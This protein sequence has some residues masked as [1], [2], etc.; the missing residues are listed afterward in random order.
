MGESIL[1]T[2]TAPSSSR[3]GPI[4]WRNALGLVEPNEYAGA[5]KLERMQNRS[6]FVLRRDPLSD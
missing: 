6:N 2:E 5:K 1:S 4:A 3:V